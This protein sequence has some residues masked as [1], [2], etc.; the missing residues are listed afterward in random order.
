MGFQ[1]A[2]AKYETITFL[3]VSFTKYNNYVEFQKYNLFLCLFSAFLPT[4]LYKLQ[5]NNP[6]SSLCRNYPHPKC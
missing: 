3:V 1:T 2:L 5:E 6:I 4:L